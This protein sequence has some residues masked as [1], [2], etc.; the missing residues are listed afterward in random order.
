VLLRM[1]TI[2]FL[3]TLLHGQQNKSF[4][5]IVSFHT[6]SGASTRHHP[7]SPCIYTPHDANGWADAIHCSDCAGPLSV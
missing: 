5:G 4:V 1:L 3:C 6:F 2:L 7:T